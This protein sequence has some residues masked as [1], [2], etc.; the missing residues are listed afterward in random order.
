M[1]LL[2]ASEE[3]KDW[4][5]VEE[6]EGNERDDL[7]LQPPSAVHL[8]ISACLAFF[9]QEGDQGVDRAHEAVDSVQACNV[10]NVHQGKS[11][12]GDCEEKGGLDPLNEME[13]CEEE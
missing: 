7:V 4:S 12:A 1:A 10:V 6:E 11:D 2:G 8:H 9:T 13:D 3:W 5:W